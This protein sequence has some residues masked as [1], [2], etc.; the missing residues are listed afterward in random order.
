MKK[1][2]VNAVDN[3]VPSLA[4]KT[5]VIFNALKAIPGVESI[6]VASVRFVEKRNTVIADV[7]FIGTIQVAHTTGRNGSS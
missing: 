7:K 5:A 1:T 6:N 2:C 3:A 4:E